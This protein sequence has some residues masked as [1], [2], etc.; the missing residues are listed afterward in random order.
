MTRDPDKPLYNI[1]DIVYL[2][3]SAALGFLEAVRVSGITRT[4][5]TWL[6][7]VYAGRM[8][9]VAPTHFGDRISLTEANFIN[10][11][12]DEFISECEALS[13][14][15]AN[16]Q[17]QL[18]SVKAQKESKYPGGCPAED[19]STTDSTA[20]ASSVDSNEHYISNVAPSGAKV[21]DLWFNTN[22]GTTYILFDDG[23]STQWV[24]A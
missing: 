4:Q 7:S 3:E 20:T 24:E 8:G 14:S 5:S 2:R 12:E 9:A 10:F 22:D 11:T 13:L 18:D 1:N 23:D 6:Y 16:L 15:V 19:S 17:R 21:G